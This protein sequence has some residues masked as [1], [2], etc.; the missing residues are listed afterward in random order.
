[1][2]SWCYNSPRN[3]SIDTLRV[4][5]CVL[6]SNELIVER[7]CLCGASYQDNWVLCGLSLYNCTE[8]NFVIETC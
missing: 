4:L 5:L 6:P 3:E 7:S 2:V 8:E 1:M